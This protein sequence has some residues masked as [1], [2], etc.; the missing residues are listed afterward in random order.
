MQFVVSSQTQQT[1]VLKT[2]HFDYDGV[3]HIEL[4]SV[5]SIYFL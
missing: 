1:D 2:Y 4:I 3:V 5:M